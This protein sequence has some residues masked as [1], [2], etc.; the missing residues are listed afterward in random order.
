MLVEAADL[1]FLDADLEHGA[2]LS[3]KNEV[4]SLRLRI[5]RTSTLRSLVVPLRNR[6]DMRGGRSRIE[7]HSSQYKI[8]DSQFSIEFD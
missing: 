1:P 7:E 5:V 8:L 6:P 3:V 4:L 2:G